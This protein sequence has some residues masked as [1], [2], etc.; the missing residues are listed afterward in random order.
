VI[1]AQ[2]LYPGGSISLIVSAVI[3]G[4]VLTETFLQLESRRRRRQRG[5]PVSSVPG[6]G[7]LSPTD[8]QSLLER[9][10]R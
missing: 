9:G 7:E 4:G 5:E 8:D 6:R 1:N 3:G 2:L 10:E